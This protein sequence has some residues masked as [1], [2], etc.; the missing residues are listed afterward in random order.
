MS[1]WKGYSMPRKRKRSAKKRSAPRRRKVEKIPDWLRE[2]RRAARRRRAEARA[3]RP[4]PQPKPPPSKQ[5]SRGVRAGLERLRELPKGEWKAIREQDEVRLGPAYTFH[6]KRWR[7][8]LDD[9]G[10]TVARVPDFPGVREM[11][12]CALELEAGKVTRASRKK[13]KLDRIKGARPDFVD[14]QSGEAGWSRIIFRGRVPVGESEDNHWLGQVFEAIPV[15]AWGQ[16][17]IGAVPREMRT[18]RGS[19]WSLR[20][21]WVDESE[22]T[23]VESTV[24]VPYWQMIAKRDVWYALLREICL[25]L[26]QEHDYRVWITQLE[27]VVTAGV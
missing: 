5:P 21:A 11:V 3:G 16:R 14:V 4:F 1:A 2:M 19:A 7:A 6:K 17:I 25:S 10:R 27:I 23:G 9:E 22:Q 15:A 24:P 12:S 8:V 18:R 26:G 20:A 13:L